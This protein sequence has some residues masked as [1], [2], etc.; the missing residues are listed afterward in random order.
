[1]TEKQ[2]TDR[3]IKALQIAAKSKLT[4]KGNTWLVPSQA[5]RGEYEVTHG[6]FEPRCTCPDYEFRQAAC[7]HVYAVQ[8]VIER[9]QTADGQTVVTET[10]KVTRK[11][12]TQDWKAYNT[13]Q[14]HEKSELQALLYE[15][16]KSLPEPEQRRGRPR[17]SL[18]DIIF[19]S[20]YKVYSTVSGRRFSTDLRE[21]KQRGYL[22]RLPHYNSVFRYLESEAL[23]VYLNELITL[24]AQPLKAVESDFAVDSSGFSTGQFMRWIDVKYGEKE[25]R[26]MWLKLHLMCGVK[27]NIVTSVQVSDGYAHDYHYFK[28]L[29]DRAAEI[30]FKLK[31]VSADKAYLGADNMLT[32]LRHGAIPY[33]PFKSNSV[34]VSQWEKKSELWTRMFH[35]YSLHRAEFLQHYHKRSNI[36]TTF[37]MIKSKFGQRL[38]SKT[39]TAQ[40]NEALCKV[41]C[42][43]LCVVIQSMHELNIAPEFSSIAA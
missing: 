5:G 41:L 42:H 38:R 29:V 4:R 8:Y 10:V 27:T 24:S 30:G 20:T 19:S 11:T 16:C 32:T 22:S 6:L 7:K 3:E 21:A 35:F 15:L 33:I 12:Y 1:M 36:E 23:T 2:I 39:L 26:R 18:A 43:N 9:E 28:P 34:G 17:L 31:E 37:H 40:I 13:A 14:T 25:D